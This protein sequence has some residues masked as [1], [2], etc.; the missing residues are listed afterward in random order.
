MPKGYSQLF[1]ILFK[2]EVTKEKIPLF[3]I[4]MSNPTEELYN[5]KFYIIYL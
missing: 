4:L 3:F 1:I 2:D 5:L